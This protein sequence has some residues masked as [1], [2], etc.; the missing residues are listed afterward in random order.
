MHAQ[1]RAKPIPFT[2]LPDE[3]DDKYNQR[4]KHKSLPV[5][6]TDF[7]ILS[8][9]SGAEYAVE[10]YNGALKKLW[11]ANIALLPEET[12]EA[13]YRNSEYAYVL[14]H[15]SEKNVGSQM[16]FRHLIELKRGKK[17]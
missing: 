3:S 14:T 1:F 6:E 12:V 10:R 8:K 5:S 16:L 17:L 15:R 11:S 7:I 13:F 9:K 2:F 4:L